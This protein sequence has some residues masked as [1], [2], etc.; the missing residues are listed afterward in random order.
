MDA[1]QDTVVAKIVGFV[2]QDSGACPVSD[3]IPALVRTLIAM[4]SMTLAHDS[5]FVG[6]G[7][8]ASR[9]IEIVERLWLYGLW[10]GSGL[11]PE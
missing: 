6:R 7:D 8:D 9:A 4:T 11:R 3:D 1:F 5:A 2:A 10:G